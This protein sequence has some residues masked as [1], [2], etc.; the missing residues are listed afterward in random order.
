MGCT[1]KFV[2]HGWRGCL[3]FLEPLDPTQ[4]IGS[5]DGTS[6]P[7]PPIV[8]G[9]GHGFRALEAKLQWR[10]AQ[11]PLNPLDSS[12]HAGHRGTLILRL[13]PYDPPFPNQLLLSS[14]AG[15]RCARSGG[16]RGPDPHES[17]PQSFFFASHVQMTGVYS[18]A[19]SVRLVHSMRSNR[20]ASLCRTPLCGFLCKVVAQYH[21]LSLMI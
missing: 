2:R 8:T 17:R 14:E 3:G 1:L 9:T 7:Q 4:Y 15:V 11:K 6:R 19:R 16:S 18:V 12:K 10:G 5:W 21:E 13:S 20:A